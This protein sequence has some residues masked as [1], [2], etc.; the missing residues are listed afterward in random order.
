MSPGKRILISNMRPFF[1]SPSL[2][3][4]S[5]LLIDAETSH[6]IA[7]VL[8]MQVGEALNLTDGCGGLVEGRLIAVSKKACTVAVE[9]R[10]QQEPVGRAVHIAIAPVKNTSRFEWFIEKATELGVRSIVPI[11]T[12]RTEKERV[13]IDRLRQLAT[14]AMLQSQQVWLPRIEEPTPLA[15]LIRAWQ[16]DSMQRL[17]A[18]CRDSERTAIADLS[19]SK[20]VGLLIGPEGDFTPHEIAT[21]EQAG[22]QEVALGDTRLRTETAGVVAATWLR[23]QTS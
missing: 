12:E 21:A 13:R 14:A 20:T 16:A 7:Q 10:S 9:H 4:G 17:I 11:I 5:T 2:A 1:Y 8:R 22:F 6:H 18:H 3:G 19:L 23:L 15:D